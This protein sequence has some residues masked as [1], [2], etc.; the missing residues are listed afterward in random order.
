MHEGEKPT[1]FFCNLEKQNFVEKTI[2]K[3]H[4]KGNSFL[5]DQKSI[6]K[7]VESFYEKLF[8]NKDDIRPKKSLKSMLHLPNEKRVKDKNLGEE[9]SVKELGEAL[10]NM[11]K[12]EK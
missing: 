3:L 6:L 2:W 9:I 4:I 11:K 7:E 1:S 12:H 8:K 5:T 10:K